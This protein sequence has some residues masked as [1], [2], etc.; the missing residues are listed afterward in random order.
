[1]IG[2]RHVRP[3]IASVTARLGSDTHLKAVGL[4][5]GGTASA[6]LL[7]LL[8]LPVLTRIFSAED[9]SVLAVYV[10][11]LT[12]LGAITCMRLDAAIPLPEDDSEVLN[13]LLL[14][15]LSATL[16]TVVLSV[17]IILWGPVLATALG[18]PDFAPFLWLVPIGV[19]FAGLYS[20][21]QYLAVRQKEFG[22]IAR[23]KLTQA[24]AGLGAQVGLG[25]AGA[26]PV[27]LMIGHGLMSGSG[28]LALARRTLRS[29]LLQSGRPSWIALRATLGRYQRFPKFS[30]AEEL[31]NNAGIQ[32]P[33]LLIGIYLLG[34]EAGF[35][36]LA[37]RVVGTP[38]TVIGGA[39]SQVY[40]AHAAQYYREGR[41]A[42]ETASVFRRL[43]IWLVLPM[44]LLGP[45]APDVFRAVFG[46]D[47]ERAGV[48][49][50]W[51][52]PWYAFR[53]IASPISM[54]MHVRMK[55]HLMLYLTIGGLLLRVVPLVIILG[56]RPEYASFTYAVTSAVFYA[57]ISVVFLSVA[58]I[59]RQAL[60]RLVAV[61][62][63]L[64][65]AAG[66]VSYIIAR[67]I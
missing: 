8:A 59:S 3:L 58:G 32:L 25:L 42:E 50:V 18:R 20:A 16:V 46:P 52:V 61:P 34:P 6:Q 54:V 11:I 45:F 63:F 26:G 62:V 36:F 9:F 7:G 49:L 5:V 66:S 40:Y 67:A 39:V 24:V 15:L 10:A 43:S 53:L 33:V 55:Q 28:A 47:W 23:T 2:P 21:F 48:L 17:A 19:A 38:M 37:M 22:S 41:L 13:L 1:M 64:W 44:A 56:W 51:M 60:M 4:L 57:L 65:V 30:V 14:A 31:A 35:L 27:G 12:L 29:G